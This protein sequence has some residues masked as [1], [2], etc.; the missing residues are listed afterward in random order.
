MPL[1]LAYLGVTNAFALL[2]LLPLS[3]RDKDT[4]ILALRH[5]I[6]L[7]ERQLGDARPRFSPSDRA[8][9]AALLHRLPADALRRL[10]LLVRPETVLR[11]HRDLLARSH[12]ARSRPRRPGRPRTVRSIRLL[13]LRLTREN[14]TWGYRRIHG[15]LL[16]LGIKVAASTVWQILKDTG[17][18]PAP[19]RTAT[20]WSA[21][22]RSQAEA[23]LACDFFE[24][25][26]LSGTRQYVLAVIEHTSRR[27]RVLGTTARPAAS[28]VTQAAR[29]L[30]M[31]L[32]DSGEHA[33]FMIRDR[34][35]KYPAL[36]D[37]VLA[38]AGIQVVLSGVRIPRMNAIME[39]W[40]HSCRRELLDR[41]LIWNQQHLLHAL[42]EYEHFYN[43]LWGVRT[44]HWDAELRRFCSLASEAGS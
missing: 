10:R 42:R 18:D 20:T 44:L 7:L 1:R 26:T 16:V 43:N 25:S 13:V 11:W 12:A 39:R 22:L 38:D 9:L 33:R 36:F 37:A 30:V 41:T 19:Q 32:E 40:I 8:F 31:D 5:Q 4:E 14:P 28:W 6:T 23:L 24:T 34:D 21:F 2:R 15:E 3:D 29:N 17:I 27:I 35:G